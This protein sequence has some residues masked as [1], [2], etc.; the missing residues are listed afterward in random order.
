MTE[1]GVSMGI[2]SRIKTVHMLMNMNSA[3]YDNFWSG[4]IYG[5]T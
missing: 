1:L 3:M 2:N 4:N 5:Y